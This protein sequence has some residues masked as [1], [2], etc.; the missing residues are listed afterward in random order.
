MGASAKR[1]K[2]SQSRCDCRTSSAKPKRFFNAF[3][4]RF[5]IDGEARVVASALHAIAK[6][7][8]EQHRHAEADAIEARRRINAHL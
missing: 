5:Q 6:I 1:R 2:R 8:R 4:A 7:R 3:T